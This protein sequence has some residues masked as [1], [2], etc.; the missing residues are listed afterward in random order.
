[1]RST[2]KSIFTV[3]FCVPFSLGLFGQL[4]KSQTLKNESGVFY[5]SR[6]YPFKGAFWQVT[7]DGPAAS[8]I[9]ISSSM[10][11]ALPW[12]SAVVPGT[13]LTAYVKDGLEP[14]PNFAD[15]IYKFDSSKYNRPFWYRTSF[16]LPAHFQDKQVWLNFNGVNKYAEIFLNG[17]KVPGGALAGMMERGRFNITGLLRRGET[18]VLAVKVAPPLYYEHHELPNFGS[19]TYI[20]SQGWD[21]MPMVPG[22]NSGITDEV[23]LSTT[24]PVDL[25]DLWIR[26][27]LPGRPDSL[28]N[29]S[30]TLVLKKAMA[31]AGESKSMQ[32]QKN[33]GSVRGQVRLLIQPGNIEVRS[34]PVVLKENQNYTLVFD[35][36]KYPQLSIKKPHLWWPNGYGGKADG[37]QYLYECKASFIVGDQVSDIDSSRFGIREFAYDTLGGPLHIYVNR[38]PVY[39]KGG[40]WGMSE[41]LLRVHDTAY[42]TRIRF[43]K[44][45]NFNMIRNWTGEVTDEAFYDACDK[46]G[47]MIWD[48]FWLNGPGPIDD[49]DSLIFKKNVEEKIKRF[50]NHA[51]LA[52]WCGA[53]EGLP[54]F[55]LNSVPN[56]IISNAIHRL[57]KNDYNDLT[58][59]LYVPRSN[60]GVSNDYVTGESRNLSGSGLWANLAPAVYFSH[61]DNGYPWS[62]N[63]WGFRSELGAACFPN[64]ESFRRFIPGDSLWPKN[65]LWD[66]HFFDD[67]NGAKPKQY[68]QD[69][70]NEYGPSTD[71][72]DFCRKAQFINLEVTKAMFEGWQEHMWR[73]ASG[74]LMWM[75]QSA[76]PSMIWQTYDYYYDLTGAYF[77]AKQAC[78]QVH[79][80]WN[81]ASDSITVVNNTPRALSNLTAR[82]KV[83]GLD[84]KEYKALAQTA[85][86][87]VAASN[88]KS[89]LALN[90]QRDN[91]AWA[92]LSPVYFLK[93]SLM[94]E[95]NKLLSDNFYWCGKQPQ[96]YQALNTLPRL[97]AHVLKR[98]MQHQKRLKN[99]HMLLTYQ[100]ENPAG[101]PGVAFGVR[102]K[103]LKQD[104]SM[105]LPI[106]LNDNYFT[107]MKGESKSIRIEYDP[108]LLDSK[109]FKLVEQAYNQ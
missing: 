68:M 59:R 75:S 54:G 5:L 19:P 107:L 83:F 42:E 92:Q 35:H 8:G 45:M 96:N 70:E 76:Y 41:Y 87:S 52:V 32:H 58:Q 72:E 15:N 102:I 100:L 34:A 60:G 86:V 108:S 28:A 62:K 14:D 57:D 67:F 38:V 81:C 97:G 66:K 10:K 18:N 69:I 50:R 24:G 23:F 40:N 77:G 106:I 3:L 90:L 99:G 98:S 95:N 29:L 73:D 1:M 85:E 25:S 39:V 89:V 43:H 11:S 12:I 6:H 13:V 55:G 61:P 7:P 4:P 20:C 71:I 78:E 93:L 49:H 94:N 2:L 21:W 46:Y 84:G 30:V 26:S 88:V 48:D 103:M 44:E 37:T 17:H 51:S 27:E 31:T 91:K 47:I 65:S 82:V 33:T 22:F 36:K 56:R 63:S 79:I 74:L 16:D 9:D 53:N 64:V 80:Q 104:G 109:G 101:S 105:L